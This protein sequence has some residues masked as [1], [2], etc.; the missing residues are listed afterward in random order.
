MS[1]SQVNEVQDAHEVG[2][3]DMSSTQ[4]VDGSEE[5]NNEHQLGRGHRIKQQPDHLFNCVNNI[6]RKLSP[7]SSS[8]TMHT[9]GKPYPIIHF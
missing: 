1:D 8:S 9:S 2:E 4:E 3:E 6:I 7:S 5:Q